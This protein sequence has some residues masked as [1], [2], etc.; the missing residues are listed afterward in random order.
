MIIHLGKEPK[1]VA[2]QTAD[3]LRLA[4][5]RA[6]V[7]FGERRLRSQLRQADRTGAPFALIIGEEEL[8]AGQV[9]VKDMAS[10]EQQLIPSESLLDWLRAHLRAAQSVECGT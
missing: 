3:D 1:G 2:L 5:I 9:A 4:G 8:Q 10:G 7:S 6:E